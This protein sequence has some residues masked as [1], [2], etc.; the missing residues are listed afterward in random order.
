MLV[1]MPVSGSGLGAR[2]T[3]RICCSADGQVVGDL[4]HKILQGYTRIL[5]LHGKLA[6]TALDPLLLPS[7]SI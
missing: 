6:I 2:G 4:K 7:P 5:G 1:S 3:S